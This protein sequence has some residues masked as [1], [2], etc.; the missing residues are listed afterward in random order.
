METIELIETATV[1]RIKMNRPQ[2]R[3]AFHPKMIEEITAAFHKI[4]SQKNIRCVVFSGEGK[5]FCAGAD[6]EWMRSMAQYTQS[7]NLKDSELLFEMFASIKNCPV[8][9]V[10][11]VQGHAMGGALGILAAS[12]IVI[13]EAQAEFC[14]S[15]TKLG[16][17]PA[18]ISA[19]VREKISS[20]AMSHLFLSA[21]VFSAGHALQ[22]GLIHHVTSDL[23]GE[24]QKVVNQI[25]A[26]G[27][28]AVRATKKLIT[29]LSQNT[30]ESLKKMTTEMIASLRVSA[31]GQEGI[32]SFLDRRE[33]QWRSRA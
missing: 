10:S 17:A 7:E 30:P 6:L 32:K 4:A 28:E 21:I 8:P 23:V 24:T 20:S 33:P 22:I 14:F 9:V 29:Q 27:P 2:V 3:N 25:C 19:F 18:V 5:S 16:L 13:A 15:E 26:N 12:D 1:V 31:E 11:V